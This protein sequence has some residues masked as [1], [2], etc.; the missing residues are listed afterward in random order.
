M[1][2]LGVAFDLPMIAL[3]AAVFH[4]RIFAEFGTGDSAVA[5]EPA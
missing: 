2:E 3:V 5:E 4:A 1:I